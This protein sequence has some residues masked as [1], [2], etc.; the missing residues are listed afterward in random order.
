MEERLTPRVSCSAVVE[1]MRAV[2]AEISMSLV[3]R[4][5]PMPPPLSVTFWD[6]GVLADITPSGSFRL[7]SN[8]SLSPC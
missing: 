4:E 6:E 3:P 1:P 2:R 7:D 5:F 8:S